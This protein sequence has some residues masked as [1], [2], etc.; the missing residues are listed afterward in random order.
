MQEKAD[1]TISKE[2]LKVWKKM[3]KRACS[4]SM[5]PSDMHMFMFADYSI[6]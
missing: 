6:T 1:M 2:M 3:K 5:G 4:A